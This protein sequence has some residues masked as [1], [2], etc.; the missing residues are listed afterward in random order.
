MSE[1]D[2]PI[3]VWVDPYPGPGDDSSFAIASKPGSWV[4]VRSGGKWSPAT[5]TLTGEALKDLWSLSDEPS[6]AAALRAEASTA[7]ASLF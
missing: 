4:L 7:F 6:K 3:D 5:F 1:L 2:S